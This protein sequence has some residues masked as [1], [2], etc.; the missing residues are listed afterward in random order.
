MVTIFWNIQETSTNMEGCP[1]FQ[2][3]I[4]LTDSVKF[5]KGLLEFLESCDGG[6]PC[7]FPVLTM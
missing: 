6:C 3:E 7:P 5:T 4:A 2:R 1:R